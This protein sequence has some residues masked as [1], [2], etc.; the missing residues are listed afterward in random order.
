MKTFWNWLILLQQQKLLLCQLENRYWSQT[1]TSVLS[2]RGNSIILWLLNWFHWCRS[3]RKPHHYPV[4]RL[5]LFYC[6]LANSSKERAVTLE[7]NFKDVNVSCRYE[8]VRAQYQPAGTCSLCRDTVAATAFVSQQV[9]CHYPSF[10]MVHKTNAVPFS[11]L[12][13]WLLFR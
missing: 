8:W 4:L 12:W 11:W 13:I 7:Q 1:E 5:G 10:P 2:R 9:Q 3:Y 6:L